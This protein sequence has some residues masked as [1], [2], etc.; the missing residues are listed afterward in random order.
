MIFFSK[1]SFNLNHS[2]LYILNPLY[3]KIFD[4]FDTCA[5]HILFEIYS[6]ITYVVKIESCYFY[7]E[8]TT[9]DTHSVR[10]SHIV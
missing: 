5:T 3:E 8:H 6:L 2:C 10:Q 1:K 4:I 9:Y 7:L